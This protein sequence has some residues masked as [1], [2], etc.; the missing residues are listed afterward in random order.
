MASWPESL[1]IELAARRCILFLGAGVSANATRADGSATHP[2]DWSSFLSILHAASRKGRR[3]DLDVAAQMIANRQYLDAA[4]ILR[5]CGLYEADYN[6]LIGHTFERYRST[7]V[8][9]LLETLDQRI[10]VTTNFD[11][12]YEDHCRQGD[13]SH[14][15]A[16]INYYD[17]GLVTRMR[18]PKHLILKVHGS[19][20]TPERTVLSKSDYFKAKAH[21]GGF[22][23]TLEGLFLTHTLLFLGYSVNDPDIQLLLENGTITAPSSTPHYALM[24]Q[25]LHPAVQS[26]FK[27]TYNVEIIEFDPSNNYEEFL[28]SLRELSLSVESLRDPQP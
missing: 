6:R 7:E 5:A 4:E 15:Y 18:S 27:R 14:G 20:E 23:K 26:A 17:D 24:A 19:V 16:V 3:E 11:T 8:H 13:A 2:P 22:F 28:S 10:V 12:I 25:G 21:Y 9:G 1:V